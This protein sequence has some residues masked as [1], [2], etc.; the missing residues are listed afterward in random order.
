VVV[1]LAEAAEDVPTPLRSCFTHDLHVGAPDYG[2]RRKLLQSML[3]GAAPSLGAHVLDD[4][5]L[6]TAGLLPRELKAVAADACAACAIESLSP[7]GILSG[8][9]SADDGVACSDLPEDASG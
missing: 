1:A 9:S 8:S 5:A 6:H 7:T 4:C 3:S 2:T